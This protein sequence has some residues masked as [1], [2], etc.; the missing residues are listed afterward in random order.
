MTKANAARIQ[1]LLRILCLHLLKHSCFQRRQGGLGKR[2]PNILSKEEDSV[3]MNIRL[4]GVE[5]GA[6][7][8]DEYRI[9]DVVYKLMEEFH[10]LAC[11]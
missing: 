1:D 3:A 7:E 8:R 4:G 2:S 11:I 10:P 9:K 5:V 6:Y